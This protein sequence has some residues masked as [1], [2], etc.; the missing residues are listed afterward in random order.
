[1]YWDKD[2]N[3]WTMRGLDFM[4]KNLKINKNNTKRH[5]AREY[6]F[7]LEPQKKGNILWI[8]NWGKTKLIGLS[9]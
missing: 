1:M 8:N 5:N 2:K 4:S 9:N 7:R 3:D 6:P